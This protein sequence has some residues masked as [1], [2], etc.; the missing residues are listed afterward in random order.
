[1]MKKIYFHQ[2]KIHNSLLS[3][4]ALYWPYITKTNVVQQ[5]SM[6]RVL[7]GKNLLL[8]AKTGS[9]KTLAII[10]PLLTRLYNLNLLKQPLSIVCFVPSDELAFQLFHIIH[11]LI[12]ANYN[13][14][15]QD[16]KYFTENNQLAMKYFVQHTCGNKKY[17]IKNILKSTILISTPKRFLKIFIKNQNYLKYIHSIYIDEID[18]IAFSKKSNKKKVTI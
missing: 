1:M 15:H 16:L 11:Q 8:S 2:Y 6:D 12:Y 18:R 9:G 17:H 14:F 4:I 13:Y 10:L 5:K 7:D 3:R